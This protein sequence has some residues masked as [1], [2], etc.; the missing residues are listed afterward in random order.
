[1]YQTGGAVETLER[2]LMKMSYN[3]T[4]K[5]Q[6]D[7][8]EFSR[9]NEKYAADVDNMLTFYKEYSGRDIRKHVQFHEGAYVLTLRWTDNNDNLRRVEITLQPER[10][11]TNH[12]TKHNLQ[13][14][15][16][17]GFSQEELK[18]LDS[19]GYTLPNR[20]K[21]VTGQNITDWWNK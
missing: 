7:A 12:I 9:L 18:H 20:H 5:A 11:A 16:V 14:P 2:S 17:Y 8:I 1:M 13:Y 4:Y 3:I 21:E 6:D 10:T 19:Q 15:Q